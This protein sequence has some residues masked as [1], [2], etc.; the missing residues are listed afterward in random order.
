MEEERVIQ[1]NKR[2]NA[3]QFVYAL[4]VLLP[5]LVFWGFLLILFVG[6]SAVM[7]TEDTACNVARVPIQGVLTTTDS[8]IGELLGMGIIVSADSIAEIITDAEE[9]DDVI[10]IVLDVDSPG[11]TPLSGDE[12]MAALSKTEKPVVAVVRDRGTSAAYWAIA[13]ADYIVASP[14]SAV[15]SIGVTM[16]YLE[17]ASSTEYIGSRWIDLS[18]GSYKD[19]GSPERVLTDEERAYFQSQVDGVHEYMIGR[20][21]TAR[22]VLS[23]EELSALADGRAFFG[24]EALS[25]KLVDELG[26]FTEA[27]AYIQNILSMSEDEVTLCAPQSTGFGGLL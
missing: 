5:A 19:A 27:T 26:S 8:G 24:E 3:W 9:D 18:S 2:R 12:V 15:G 10:A 23:Y 13:G 20:I 1:T 25:L 22:T 7:Y 11:G 21:S 6:F 17:I 4:I 14:V 16:S